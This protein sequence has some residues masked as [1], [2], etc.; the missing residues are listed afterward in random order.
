MPQIN[1]QTYL[2][3][4]QYRDAANLDAR[5][6]LHVKF[7]VNKQ[8]W[9]RWYFD[10]LDLPAHARVLE[11][12][13]GPGYLWRDNLDRIPAGWAITLSDFSAGMLDQ[14]RTNLNGRAFHFEIIDAQSIPYDDGTFDAVIANHMLYHVPD[15]A[16]A[17]SEMRRV[18]KSNGAAHL[19]TNGERHLAELDDLTRLFE[20]NTDFGFGQRAH[21]MFSIDTGG[22]EVRQWFASVEV[23][24]YD[25]A[26]I[27]TEVQPLVDYILSMVDPVVAAQRRAELTAFV[28]RELQVKGAIH[29]TKDSGVFIAR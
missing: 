24:R 9:N 4:D 5:V 15:R 29:I 22:D 28:E 3:T 18:L 19:A 14:A 25:D 23:R 1:D 12:G 10:Q 21:E 27:V 6:Q 26:L 7:S 20:P 2:L 8:G 11:L 17:L 13:C 16:R